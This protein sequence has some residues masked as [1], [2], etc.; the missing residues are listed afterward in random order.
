MSPRWRRA[1]KMLL[2]A[3]CTSMTISIGAGVSNVTALIF[4]MRCKG[5][6][7]PCEMVELLNRDGDTCRAG[8]YSL[9]QSDRKKVRSWLEE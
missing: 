4:A 2:Q 9:S 3:P 6:Q 7:I 1:F 8:K 5:L